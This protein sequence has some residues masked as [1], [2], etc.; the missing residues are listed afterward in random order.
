MMYLCNK[1]GGTQDNGLRCVRCGWTGLYD[2]GADAAKVQ[3]LI[4]E[5]LGKTPDPKP[6]TEATT[7]AELREQRVLLEIISIRIYPS[8][9]G[10]V[11]AST[12]RD[13]LQG[14]LEAVVNHPTG[15][16]VGVGA[17][18]ASAIE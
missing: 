9:D 4:D 18:E 5:L 7:L 8:I 12:R 16:F 3:P 2:V 13:A 14:V 17:T 10:A 6:I 11:E 1:C 15:F